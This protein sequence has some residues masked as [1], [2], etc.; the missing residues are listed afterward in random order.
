MN[1]IH[2]ESIKIHIPNLLVEVDLLCFTELFLLIPFIDLDTYKK[3]QY[4]SQWWNEGLY[5]KLFFNFSKLKKT[6]LIDCDVVCLPFKFNENDVR[7]KKCCEDAIL[8]NK[9]TLY[10]RN[11]SRLLKK[12]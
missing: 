9:K 8:Y 12:C 5:T 4:N 3:I 7:V 11:H 6:N 1:V 10:E 2:S